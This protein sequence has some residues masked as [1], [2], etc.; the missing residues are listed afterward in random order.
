[1]YIFAKN[2]ILSIVAHSERPKLL[3]VRAPARN[4]LRHYWPNADKMIVRTDDGDYRYRLVLP[5]EAVATK[6]A[7]AITSI[8]YPKVKPAVS[9]DRADTYF[10]VW[11]VIMDIQDMKDVRP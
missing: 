4:D 8:D 1:M 9:A 7:R 10:A 11:S 5:R 6:I 3:M 2:G